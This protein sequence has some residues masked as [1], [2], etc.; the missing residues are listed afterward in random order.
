M[1]NVI[2]TQSQAHIT[3]L[4]K[5]KNLPGF[6]LRAR[7]KCTKAVQ[8]LACLI[9]TKDKEWPC[10]IPRQVSTARYL[11]GR[12]SESRIMPWI[13]AWQNFRADRNPRDQLHFFLI[14]EKLKCKKVT[15]WSMSH[16]QKQGSHR[17]LKQ[18]MSSW[19][20]GA[21]R[22]RRKTLQ[23][24]TW[25]C[26]CRPLVFKSLNAPAPG[27]YTGIEAQAEWG[28]LVG[29]S[30]S[31]RKGKNQWYEVQPGFKFG[32]WYETNLK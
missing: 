21:Y 9:S 13:L 12:S 15:I 1:L 20:L 16:G 29:N 4:A 8:G 25:V 32:N 2:T 23:L 24:E 5:W 17:H 7:Q 26:F 30:Q 3:S 11:R 18:R 31:V 14:F 19:G 6:L 22:I 27:T 28:T 10:H